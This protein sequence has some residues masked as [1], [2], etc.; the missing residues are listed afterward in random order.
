M[1]NHVMTVHFK[2]KPYKCDLC[3]Y[4]TKTKKALE[5][6]KGKKHNDVT[7][8]YQCQVCPGSFAQ[9]IQLVNHCKNIHNI[10]NTFQCLQCGHNL[11]NMQALRQHLSSVHPEWQP[12]KPVY[13]HQQVPQQQQVLQE[14][15][16]LALI[17]K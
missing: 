12:M 4:Q 6:H 3:E 10:E 1:K 16:V 14:Q 7:K 8:Q 17:Q 5:K 11:M 9:Q 2:E 15:N 13:Y